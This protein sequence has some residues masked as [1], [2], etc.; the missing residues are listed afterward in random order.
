MAG[1]GAEKNMPQQA[2]DSVSQYL[3]DDYGIVLHWPAYQRYRMGKG[4]ISTYPPGYKENGGIFC[5][6]NPWIVIAEALLGR[7]DRA[8]SYYR[9]HAPG[10]VQE[11]SD[12]H[13]MEPYVYCQMIAGPEAARHGEAKNSWLTGTASWNF[14]AAS[15]YLLGISPDFDGLKIDPS[16]PSDWK[17]FEVIRTYRGA[18]LRI[19]IDNP[20]GV[21]KGVKEILLDGKKLEGNVI[22][23]KEK[24]EYKVSV[25]MG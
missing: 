4:E 10:Y 3:A 18:V 19:E 13:R 1:I 17:H 16:I 9:R 20:D 14:V 22:P 7:G 11:R 12:I 24:G 21:S 15:Q 5:H 8:F 6:N 23:P 25:R 2:L